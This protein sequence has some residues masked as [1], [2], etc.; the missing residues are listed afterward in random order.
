M[1]R[2]TRRF[3]SVAWLLGFVWGA[4]A[5]H[6][7]DLPDAALLRVSE[8]HLR[9]LV[10]DTLRPP[11]S[12]AIAGE[13]ERGSD[14]ISDLR[15]RVEFAPPALRLDDRGRAAVETSIL[16]ASLRIGRL[17]RRFLSRDAYC[18]EFGFDVFPERP[19]PVALDLRFALDQHDLAIVPEAVTF[20]DARR[21]FRLVR[22]ARCGNAGIP[23]WLLWWLGRSRIR[24][25]VAGADGM[26]LDRLRKRSA[27]IK[28][29]GGLLDRSWRGLRVHPRAVETHDGALHVTL[30][31]T[32]GEAI[33]SGLPAR[34]PLP[35]E[36]T[37]LAVSE[38]FAHRLLARSFDRLDDGAPGESGDIRKLLASDAIGVLVPGLRDREVGEVVLD[39]SLGGPPEVRFVADEYGRALVELTLRD[40]RLTLTEGDG[41]RTLGSLVVTRGEIAARPY[42]GVLGGVS[43]ELVRNRWR[44]RSSGVEFDEGILAATLTELA[45]GLSFETSFD[46][47]ATE[48]FHIGRTRFAPRGF[49]AIDGYLVIELEP[50][51]VSQANR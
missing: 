37:Y 7:A 48:S 34:A 40:A 39:V 22:P 45:F 24:D 28:E 42:S 38:A 30:A 14:G 16:D 21:G 27:E 5:A 41:M 9:T 6:A 12:G 18:E 10:E 3:R 1:R 44:L 36:G 50:E 17:E 31:V 49:R 46:P 25:Y 51:P 43:L 26:V 20:T 32:E 47:L 23:S 19:V 35:I 11:G 33:A 15:Y 2:D 4:G 29:E 13:G 8:D